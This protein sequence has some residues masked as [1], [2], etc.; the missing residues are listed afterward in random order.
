M[1]NGQ[2]KLRKDQ[3]GLNRCKEVQRDREQKHKRKKVTERRAE[4]PPEQPY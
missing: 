3:R 1:Q 4:R 2:V